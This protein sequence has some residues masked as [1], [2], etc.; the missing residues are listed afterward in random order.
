[1]GGKAKKTT[2]DHFS[3]TLISRN[4]GA[5]SRTAASRLTIL[6]HDLPVHADSIRVMQFFLLPCLTFSLLT[7]EDFWVFLSFLSDRSV[8]IP[9]DKCAEKILRLLGKSRKNQ[10]IP[11]N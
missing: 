5:S 2:F 4:L 3:P 7:S 8:F 6:K 1:M 11:T 10:E 9:S